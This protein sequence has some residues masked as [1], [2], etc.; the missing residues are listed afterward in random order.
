MVNIKKTLLTVAYLASFSVANP[1]D[2]SIPQQP[3]VPS[4]PLFHI[5]PN[6]ISSLFGRGSSESDISKKF[7]E[8]VQFAGGLL[9]HDEELEAMGIPADSPL[10]DKYSE[11]FK[12]KGEDILSGKISPEAIS[13][14]LDHFRKS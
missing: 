2:P 9:P 8:A 5:I 4:N 14:A 12:A 7:W 13:S 11:F 1:S 3:S 6:L 10:W